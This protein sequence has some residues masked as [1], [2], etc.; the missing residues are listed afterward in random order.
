MRHH[1]RLVQRGLTVQEDDVAVSHVPKD[2][3]VPRRW[4][5]T[6]STGVGLSLWGEELIG[7]RGPLLQRRPVLWSAPF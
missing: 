4:S 3:L 6:V 7:D 5:V 2:L 1:A